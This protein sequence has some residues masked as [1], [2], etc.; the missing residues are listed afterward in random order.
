M[1]APVLLSAAGIVG[2]FA[3]V[4]AAVAEGGARLDLVVVFPVVSGSSGLFLGGVLL[5]VLGFFSLPF[6]LAAGGGGEGPEERLDGP[7]AGPASSG[8]SG[9]VLLL[10]PVPI[11]FGAARGVSRRARWTAVAVGVG[12]TIA[13]VALYVTIR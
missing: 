7:N 10:G 13:A 12:L 8:G 3:L 1:R 11:F 6:T 5:V 4:A 9:G 2:G